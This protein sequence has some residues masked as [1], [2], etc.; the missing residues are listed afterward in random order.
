MSYEE[1]VPMLISTIGGFALNGLTAFNARFNRWLDRFTPEQRYFI[2]ALLSGLL[3]AGVVVLMSCAGWLTFLSCGR[4]IG[5][6]L[7]MSVL[8]SATGNKAG[9]N[10]LK[11]RQ[12]SATQPATTSQSD[13]RGAGG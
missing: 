12:K 1:I 8:G 10:L 6:Q 9:Y 4:D 3:G 2:T 5:P 7:A 13:E 11:T